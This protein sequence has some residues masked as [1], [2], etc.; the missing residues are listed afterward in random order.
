MIPWTVGQQFQDQEFPLLSGARIVRIAV[1]PELSGAGYGS[2]AV[3]CLKNYFQG[4][5]QSMEE[6]EEDE[7]EKQRLERVNGEP[8]G[9]GPGGTYYTH[10]HGLTLWVRIFLCLLFVTI[11]FTISLGN[12]TLRLARPFQK[13]VH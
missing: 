3:E 2:R 12:H 10:P 8:A 7:D 4:L 6:D 9:P 5:I 13:K 11:Y 1:H